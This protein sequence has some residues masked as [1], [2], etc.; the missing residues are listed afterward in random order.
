MSADMTDNSGTTADDQSNR[1][2]ALSR[3]CTGRSN[4]HSIPGRPDIALSGPGVND[5]RVGEDRVCG[6][7]TLQPSA[8][9]Y[10]GK[11]DPRAAGSLLSYGV[12]PCSSPQVRDAYSIRPFGSPV[13]GLAA[14]LYGV[15]LLIS[16][17]R[18]YRAWGGHRHPGAD[19]I[20][21]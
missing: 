2:S 3:R 17:P 8:K 21:V 12:V 10:G 14:T 16:G 18:G 7:T 5:G 4:R 20:W 9:P 13:V 6:A 1:I 19:Q 15:C 11:N